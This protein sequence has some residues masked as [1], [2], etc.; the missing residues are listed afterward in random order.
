V[1]TN[2]SRKIVD[3]DSERRVS[4]AVDSHYNANPANP[5]LWS[6][7]DSVRDAVSYI[8]N[9]SPTNTDD[10]I[11]QYLESGRPER[12]KPG[13]FKKVFGKVKG[14]FSSP[15]PK[16]EI[17]KFEMPKRTEQDFRAVADTLNDLV[18]A[19][20]LIRTTVYNG[21]LRG[22]M[23][24]LLGN[25]AFSK[26][27]IVFVYKDL[28]DPQTEQ[29]YKYA[30]DLLKAAPA[31][32]PA[33]PAAPAATPA[34]PAAPAATPAAPAAPAATPAAPAATPAAPAATPAAP[35]ATIFELR[36]LANAH[37][38]ARERYMRLGISAP[39]PG[40]DIP[41]S[42]DDFRE[43]YVKTYLDH[44]D[45]ENEDVRRAAL[46]HAIK[47]LGKETDKG[48]EITLAEIL[49][50]IDKK[51]WNKVITAR[52]TSDEIS[53]AISDGDIQLDEIP[54]VISHLR[55]ALLS[56]RFDR[57]NI[58][59]KE[60][61][62]PL[63]L[64]LNRLYRLYQGLGRLEKDVEQA[65]LGSVESTFMKMV[66][67][68]AEESREILLN[69][70]LGGAPEPVVESTEEEAEGSPQPASH[71]TPQTIKEIFAERL[72]KLNDDPLLREIVH[73]GFGVVADWMLGK[74]SKRRHKSHN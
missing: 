1:A 43:A 41:I 47:Q 3:E 15:K 74:I 37:K 36:L 64:K 16:V 66:A 72:R 38:I 11:G 31:A 71:E 32:T 35:A 48:E 24:T 27:E 33:A 26:P 23:D 53:K 73:F 7:R 69:A 52:S 61:L 21:S 9:D 14:L 54:E 39:A 62:G 12:E 18:P 29:D 4:E 6:V 28:Q 20:H 30:I 8:L 34:A 49:K 57:R 59:R 42:P 63:I 44:F 10:I 13:F 5:E 51:D 70:R 58:S 46:Q 55:S 22:E 67:D 56:G 2:P 25:E 50:K 40:V 60:N 17:G 65:S 19:R 68:E 45:F